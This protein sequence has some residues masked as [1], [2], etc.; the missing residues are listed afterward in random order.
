[1]AGILKKPIGIIVLGLY[2]VLG[3][4]SFR[5]HSRYFYYCNL[6]IVF[7]LQLLDNQTTEC[8]YWDWENNSWSTDG[9]ETIEKKETGITTCKSS[10]LTNFALLL[11][12]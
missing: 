2:V 4:G 9:V 10:H 6:V 3:F 11:V 12:S 1:M 8:N 5:F 7:T